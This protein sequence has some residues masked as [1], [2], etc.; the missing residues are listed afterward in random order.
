MV[1]QGEFIHRTTEL[2][3]T[4]SSLNSLFPKRVR[5][6]VSP[7]HSDVA[8]PSSP[9]RLGSLVLIDGHSESPLMARNH[10]RRW[11]WKNLGKPRR[12]TS[13]VLLQYLASTVY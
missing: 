7:S 12:R 9:S 10:V 2:I 13:F 6:Q 11:I 5:Y 4:V 1:C 3:D 8:I